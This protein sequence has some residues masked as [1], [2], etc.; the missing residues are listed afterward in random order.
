MANW[1]QTLLF[2]PLCAQPLGF[3]SPSLVPES[4]WASSSTIQAL[5]YRDH[6]KLGGDEITRS[7]AMSVPPLKRGRAII[8]GSLADLPLSVGSF[9]GETWVP[10]SD[11]PSWLNS[12]AS[13]QTAWHR[14]ANTLDDFI[15]YGWS[16]WAVDRDDSGNIVDAV[17]VQRA[18][19]EFDPNVVTGIRVDNAPL[20][21][22]SRVLLFQGPDEG[23]LATGSET[24]RGARFIEQAWVNRVRNPIPLQVLQEVVSG[25]GSRVT[26]QQARAYVSQWSDARKDSAGAIGFLPANLKMEVFGE[27][28]ADLFTEGRNNVRLDIAN[29]LNLPASLLDGSTAT[30]SLT[31]VTQEGQRTSLIDFLEYYMAPLEARLSMPDVTPEGTVA[32]FNRSNLTSVPN[33]SHGP[34]DS[35]EAVESNDAPTQEVPNADV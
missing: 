8:V 9:Q 28:E 23:I 14:K 18:R 31:Y 21:D 1:F 11:Q 4:P 25:S 32:R 6:F 26:D 30:A 16:L 12:S 19:W 3:S 34:E 7:T 22:P 27:T 15:I 29:L 20:T 33:D 2:G 10:V 13:V 24:I 5:V 17:H 35:T